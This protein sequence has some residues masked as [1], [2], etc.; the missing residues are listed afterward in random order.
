MMMHP[1]MARAMAKARIADL[2]R[3]PRPPRHNPSRRTV[4]TLLGWVMV[5]TGLRLLARQPQ[6]NPAYR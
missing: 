5:E 4:G 1:E 3:P 6:M 2:T